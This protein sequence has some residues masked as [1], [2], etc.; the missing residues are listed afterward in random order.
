MA[1]ATG[2]DTSH[3]LQPSGPSRWTGEE[4]KW[5]EWHFEIV[6]WT[7][8]HDRRMTELML[9]ASEQLVPVDITDMT[10][11]AVVL[12]GRLMSDLAAK[13]CD[14]ARRLLMT[15][16]D[17]GNGFEAWR[18]LCEK[19]QGGGRLRKVGLLNQILQYKFQAKDFMDSFMQFE[20]LIKQ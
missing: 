2:D 8:R 9:R 16:E 20:G 19:G 17:Q 15:L 18:R 11:E 13:T 12:S 1:T 14:R 3:A 7:R 6:Q 4:E 10:D 5:V